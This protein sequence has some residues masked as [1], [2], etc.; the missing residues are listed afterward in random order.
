MAVLGGKLEAKRSDCAP[1]AGKSTLN[2]LELSRAKPS[3]YHKI[4]YDAALIEAVFVDVFLDAHT[5]PPSQIILDLDATD[6]PLHGHQEGRFFHGYYD[7]YCYLPLYVFCGRHLLV[8]KRRPAD[9]DAS[10]TGQARG[11]KAHGSVEEVARVVARI[12]QRWPAVRLL[13]RA[14]AGFAGE[15]LMA[16]CEDNAVDFLFGLARNSRLVDAI[17]AELAEAAEHSQ[18]TGKSAR[19]FKDFAWTTRDSWSRERRVV[20]KAEWTEGQANPRFVVTSLSREEHEARH[21][22]EKL[23]CARGEMEN[24]IKSLPSRKRGSAS[25]TFMPIVPLF[26]P[27]AGSRP[28]QCAPTSCGCGLPRWPMCC[29]APCAASA[30]LMLSSPAPPAA[31]SASSCSRSARLCAPACV[32]SSSPCPRL[33]HT[34]PSTAP[35]MP[36]MPH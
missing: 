6:D 3:R 17:K 4:S 35:P 5:A 33:S 25:S 32:A 2:R 13:L 7:N 19:R 34:R 9:I 11:L 36:P 23:C 16:W 1:L 8:A 28:K 22:Y 18:Q 21:L 14:D 27:G 20:A 26:G 29:C 10:P 30:W 15:A 31:P 12:R 24:R